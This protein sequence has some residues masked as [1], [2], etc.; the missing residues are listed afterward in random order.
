MRSKLGGDDDGTFA[1]SLKQTATFRPLCQRHRAG[2]ARLDEHVGQLPALHH[3]VAGD[4]LLLR[5]ERDA[6]ICLF[7]RACRTSSK[8]SA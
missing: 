3:R 1:D 6:V 8:V 4:L 2:Y 5:G 7:C